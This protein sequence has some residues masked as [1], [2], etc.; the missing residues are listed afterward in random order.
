VSELMYPEASI[1]LR[2]CKIYVKAGLKL[3]QNPL[4]IAEVHLPRSYWVVFGEV[5]TL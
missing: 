5:R 1:K 3:C 2:F 4:E